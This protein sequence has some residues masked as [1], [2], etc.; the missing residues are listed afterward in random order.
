MPVTDWYETTI[1]GQ[2]WLIIG[3]AQLR[4]P[5]PFVPGSQVFIAVAPPAGGIANIG[6]LVKGDAGFPANFDETV[7]FTALE[8]GDP[9][10]DFMRLTKLSPATD[11]SGPLFQVV[12]GLHKGAPGNDGATV[13]TPSNYGTPA[14]K[15]IL[16]VNDDASAFVYQSQKV[17]DWWLPAS[18]NNTA[19]G[20]STSTLG[21]VS[22]DPQ[23]TDWRPQVE[24]QTTVAPTGSNVRVDLIA[25][26]NGETDG[27]DVGRGFGISGANE[28][29]SICSGPP[30]GS[31]ADYD[32]VPAGQSATVH[33]RV[34]RQSGSDT[35]TTS[36]T[37]TRYRVKVCPTP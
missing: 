35:F 34:E 16:I 4:V 18:L 13:L 27:T 33:L 15:K 29:I 12:A 9:T 8:Y 20:N 2:D 17:G 37:T 26:L 36:A 28:R 30:P 21:V 25:R 5:L 19:P 1:D 10:P 14:P 3:L 23:D 24:A 7:D 32:L 6:A 22:I 11:V 31:A